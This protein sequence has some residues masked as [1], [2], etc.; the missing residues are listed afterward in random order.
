V[1]AVTDFPAGHIVTDPECTCRQDGADIVDFECA[2]VW[3]IKGGGYVPV[4]NPTQA[5][6]SLAQIDHHRRAILGDRE[7]TEGA[8]RGSFLPGGEPVD[9]VRYPNC[10]HAH[11]LS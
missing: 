3:T 1:R 7:R 2:G 11:Q 6:I 4:S 9:T 5:S 10:R 8:L